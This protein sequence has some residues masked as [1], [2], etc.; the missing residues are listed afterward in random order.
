M[1]VL[2]ELNHALLGMTVDKSIRTEFGNRFS[3][4]SCVSLCISAL[5]NMSQSI[6]LM[7]F[8]I[9]INFDIDILRLYPT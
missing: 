7:T 8:D 6:N 1:N 5:H 2:C 9:D 3:A 4:D